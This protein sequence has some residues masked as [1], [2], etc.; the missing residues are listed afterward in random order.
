MAGLVIL[1]L[2]CALVLAAAE[3]IHLREDLARGPRAR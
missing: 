1:V 3:V 2:V